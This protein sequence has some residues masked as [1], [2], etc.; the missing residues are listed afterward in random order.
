[1]TSKNVLIWVEDP[2]RRWV[3]RIRNDTS[4]CRGE[5]M[6]M[7]RVDQRGLIWFIISYFLSR[8]IHGIPFSSGPPWQE[9]GLLWIKYSQRIPDGRHKIRIRKRIFSLWSENAMQKKLWI[10]G[11]GVALPQHILSEKALSKGKTSY[12]FIPRA[13]M[14]DRV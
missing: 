4:C 14:V 7:N 1:M 12:C 11:C 2:G 3:I 8:D 13:T 5:P 10:G 9:I 6:W